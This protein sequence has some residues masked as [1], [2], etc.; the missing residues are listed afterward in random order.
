MAEIFTLFYDYQIRLNLYHFQT[1]SYAG[2]KASDAHLAKFKIHFDRFLEVWQGV[3]GKIVFKKSETIKLSNVKSTDDIIEATLTI[4]KYL[5]EL[6]RQYEEDHQ[7]LV[8]LIDEILSD[9]N[10]FLYLLT[11]E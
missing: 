3:F 9:N 7:Y 10:Q 4:N 1:N 8:N 11:F 2:H 6:A 5:N